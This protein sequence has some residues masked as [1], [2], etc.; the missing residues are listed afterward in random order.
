VKRPI[1]AAFFVCIALAAATGGCAGRSPGPRPVVGPEYDLTARLSPEAHR[2][3]VS[4]TVRLPPATASRAEI[5]LSLSERM[6]QLRVEIIEPSAGAG[7]ATLERVDGNGPNVR[8]LV[9][10]PRPCPPGQPILLRFSCAGSG[11]VS[12]MYYIGPEVAFASAWGSD[13]YPLVEGDLDKGTG[14][15]T[16]SVP[17]GWTVATGGV[18]R[19]TGEQEALGTFRSAI[20]HATYFSFVA[21]KYSV[22]RGDGAVRLSAYLLTGRD[23]IDDYLRGVQGI[24]TTL[25]REFGPY[26]FDE[27]ALV[28]VP[29]E[30]ANRAGFNAVGAA[31]MLVLNS[32]AFDAPD[33][34]YLLEWLG[35]ELSHQWFPHAVALRTPPGLY[36]EE[37]LAEYGGLRVV[38]TIEGPDAAKQMRTTG[39]QYDPIYS[40]RAYFTL[41][42]EGVDRPLGDLQA[43][44]EHRNLAYN[45]GFLVFDML[46]REIGRANFQRILGE[47]V[48]RHRFGYLTWHEFLEAIE[49]GSGRKLDWFFEQWFERAGAPEWHLSWSQQG[50]TLSGV[51]TQLEP[52]Y[53]AALK[54]ELRGAD[55]Q[56]LVRMVETTGPRA[57]FSFPVGFRVLSAIVDPDHEILRWTPEFRAASDSARAQ[58]AGSPRSR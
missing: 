55:G 39:F 58:H 51:L 40:A 46:S 41:V 7:V 56:G 32:R 38:E 8:W 6:D 28:E 26:P 18:R 23:R 2:L 21:G 43:K 50:D 16:V 33:T 34:K 57:E 54:V 5:A 17:T 49:E 9:R 25:T 13:W 14:T 37:A 47:I 31:G 45:K 12:S 27:L 35:H 29:R 15:I 52:Y 30:L 36:M 44:I 22:V 4:G 24:L 53:R 19:S 1:V 11:D 48:R 3:E 10:A 42:G 20:L